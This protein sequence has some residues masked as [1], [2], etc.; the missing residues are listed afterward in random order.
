MRISKHQAYQ[1]HPV[2]N[3]AYYPRDPFDREVKKAPKLEYDESNG[4]F[5]DDMDEQ[6]KLF[7]CKTCDMILSYDELSSHGCED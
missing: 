5:S 3:H 4:D 1:G 7:K 6:P 2:P